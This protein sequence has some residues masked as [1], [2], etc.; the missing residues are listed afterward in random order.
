MK[1]VKKY[2]PNIEEIRKR[3]D[4]KG[5]AVVF[6]Y[7]DILYAPDSSEISED[8]MV[9]EETHSMQQSTGVKEWWDRYYVDKEFRLEQELE[10]YRNQYQWAKENL[11]R[12]YKRRLL[13]RIAGDLSSELYGGIVSTEEAIKLIKEEYD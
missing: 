2:P 12:H 10:A 11:N 13:K 7:G 4:I 6:T 9:H 1:V 8:L 3:F 5:R